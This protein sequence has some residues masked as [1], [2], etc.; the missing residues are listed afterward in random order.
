MATNN[1]L[2]KEL[3]SGGTV[4]DYKHAARI[5]LDANYR[6]APK[7]AFLFHVAFDVDVTL[8]M[9]GQEQILEAGLLVKQAQLPQFNVETKPYNA[10]NRPNIVQTKIK[11]TP[12]DIV[13]HD[14]NADVV[15]DFWY[16]YYNYYFRDSDTNLVAQNAPHKYQE[17]ITDGWGYTPRL[18]S[19]TPKILRSIRIYVLHQKRFTEYLLVNPTITRWAGSEL[20]VSQGTSTVDSRMTVEYEAVIFSSGDLVQDNVSSFFNLK[21]DKVA[22]DIT[23]GA[24]VDNPGFR[25]PGNTSLPNM[26]RDGY[27]KVVSTA[28][29]L[30]GAARD[31]RN[32]IQQAQQF[33]NDVRAFQTGIQD[34]KNFGKYIAQ[35]SN[36]FAQIRVPDLTNLTR[37]IAQSSGQVGR[38][39][40]AVQG[41]F[42]NQTVGNSLTTTAAPTKGGSIVSNQASVSSAPA[43]PA[44]WTSSADG[45]RPPL[46]S[47]PG[48][49]R[50]PVTSEQLNAARS[51]NPG[52]VESAVIG[53][54]YV[55]DNQLKLTKTAFT[56]SKNLQSDQTVANIVDRLDSA[57]LEQQEQQVF[58]EKYM[59]STSGPGPDS[60]DNSEWY[61]GS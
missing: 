35:G 3:K 50:A 47:L 60:D 43:S 29:E 11:Y 8:S 37:G 32:T 14:D 25:N 6:L 16:N 34:F 42:G 7:N 49:A 15:R 38:A 54:G 19:A 27:R 51:T 5:F 52:N 24:A 9:Q 40:G 41:I 44:Y 17:R 22:S 30:A 55:K 46:P 2:L 1:Y 20:D 57:A 53:S 12:L 45:A 21:Y 58:V 10:Y 36:P 56:N 23:P 4:K 39:V 18:D 26:I 59:N 48:N 28:G 61:R 13:F 33:K 31:I